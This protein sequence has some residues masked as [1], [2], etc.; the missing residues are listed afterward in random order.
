[1][2]KRQIGS[3]VERDG[4]A[5]NARA[6][7]RGRRVALA[8]A[9]ALAPLP[10]LAFS[11]EGLKPVE[12]NAKPIRRFNALGNSIGELTFLGGIDLR[13]RAPFASLSGLARTGTDRFV[14]VSDRG[15]WARI[16]LQ[17]DASGRME[18]ASAWIGP[19]P[20]EVQG[21]LRDNGDVDAEAIAL[22]GDGTAL[23]AF[24]RRNRITRF[25]RD[26]R[27]LGAVPIVIPA[28]ELRR[29]KGLETVAVA[30]ASSPLKGA[31]IT[32][33]ERSIDRAGDIFGA[34]LEGPKRGVFTVR[35]T[36][37][38]DVTDAAFLPS[39]DLVMLERSYRGRLSLRVR[40]R[41]IAGETIRPGARLDGAVLMEAGLASEIDNLEGLTIHE[42]ERGTILTVVSDDNN[43]F[44]QRTL[45][46]EFRLEGE[47]AAA[48]VPVPAMRPLRGS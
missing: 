26:G 11:P 30:P 18:A 12:L 9:L 25:A 42:D 43:S 27:R 3:M 20:V 44:L 37:G 40:M 17:R 22:R 34:V 8:F 10:A 14:A 39:G 31:A 4:K 23:V 36:D 35:R 29:N 15:D 46:L 2:R 28:S 6:F 5:V 1:M 38:F 33:A 7:S 21:R 24:E 45:L 32:I 13:G 41:R 47:P 48:D 19:I 16:E